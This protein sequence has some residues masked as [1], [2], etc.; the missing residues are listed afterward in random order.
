MFLLLKKKQ[1]K[2]E[3]E[4][5]EHIT[6]ITINNTTQCHQTHIFNKHTATLSF[7]TKQKKNKIKK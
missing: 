5:K 6:F 1:K 4:A 7:K 3:T 2:H